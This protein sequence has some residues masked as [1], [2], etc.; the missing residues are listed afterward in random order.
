MQFKK[1]VYIL[2]WLSASSVDLTAQ[3]YFVSFTDK[4]NNDYSIDSPSQFLS[5]GAIDRRDKHNI[6]ITTEDLPVS[7]YYL[8]SLINM[9][10]KVIWP[11]KWLNGAIIETNNLDLM[12]TITNVSFISESKLIYPQFVTSS[13]KKYDNYDIASNNFLKSQSAYGLTWDQT[14]TVNGHVLHENGYDG[15]GTVIAILDGGFKNSN[16]LSTINHLWNNEQVLSYR[17]IVNPNS[18]FFDVEEDHGTNVFSVIGGYSENEFK[19]S[20]PKAKF[21]LIRTEDSPTEYPIEEYN[22]VIGA[23]YADSIGA[24][25]INSSLGYFEFEGSF[26]DY[27]YEDFNGKTTIVVKGAEIAFSKGMVVVNS[28]GNEGSNKWN[29]IV[30]PADGENVLAVGAIKSDSIR[31][32]FSSYGPSYDGRVKPDVS[33]MGYRTYVQKEDG[34]ISTSNGTSFSAPVITGFLACLWQAMPQL[35]NSEL[36]QLVKQKCHLFSSPDYSLGYGIPDF[37]RA[38]NSNNITSIKNSPFKLY[39]NPVNEILWLGNTMNYDELVEISIFD[40][41]G[42]LVLSQQNIVQLP[43]RIKQINQLSSGLY[44]VRIQTLKN[45][46]TGKIFKK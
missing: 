42:K 45:T 5:Q 15:N 18:S 7:S 2:I 9:N 46:Y 31:A 12:D 19:G 22:W 43:I 8:D 44:L 6:E 25:I 27:T 36:V 20:A 24:D 11:S 33:A 40:V 4:S 17:D 34:N 26:K 28:A 39:P 13:F 35:K 32:S 37:N 29:K 3:K 1:I 30:S 16:I 23:E 14:Q 21:H 38:L 41:S 10:I